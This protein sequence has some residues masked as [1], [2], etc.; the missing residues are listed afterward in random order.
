MKKGRKRA[1]VHGWMNNKGMKEATIS[2]HA[3]LD[4]LIPCSLELEMGPAFLNLII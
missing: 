2:P 4:L 1:T 3:H